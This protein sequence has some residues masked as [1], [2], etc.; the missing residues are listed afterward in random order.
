MATA[1]KK[2]TKMDEALV[3]KDSPRSTHDKVREYI[4]K[5]EEQDKLAKEID[6]LRAFFIAEYDRIVPDHKD[7]A[8]PLFIDEGRYGILMYDDNRI[9]FDSATFKE[10]NPELYA[11]Y[12]TKLIETV[13]LMPQIQLTKINE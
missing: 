13:K 11:Q 8:K 7:T 6:E 2:P 4:K 12:K 10:Q 1:A 5:K 3:V 9:N